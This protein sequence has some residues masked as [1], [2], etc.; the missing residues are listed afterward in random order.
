MAARIAEVNG[1]P[2]SK[3]VVSSGATIKLYDK[4]NQVTILTKL[5]QYQSWLMLGFG[6][7]GKKW[8]RSGI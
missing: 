6:A 8:K 4:V 7:S 5:S 3:I 1:R 2:V